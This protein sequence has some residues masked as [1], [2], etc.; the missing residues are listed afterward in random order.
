VQEAVINN[1]HAS[2]S[3]GKPGRPFGTLKYRTIEDL[4]IAID[5]YFEDTKTPYFD[6]NGSVAGYNPGPYT[7]AG[8]ACALGVNRITLLRY[9]GHNEDYCNAL[10]HARARVEAYAE[11]RLYDRDG[12]NGAKFALSNNHEG[13]SEAKQGAP[14]SALTGDDALKLIGGIVKLLETMQQKPRELPAITITDA[15]YEEK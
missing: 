7:M 1:N 2:F 14:S 12:S 5:E 10:T 13:W 6:K 11:G 15:P 4:Q 8:L 9:E 3:S